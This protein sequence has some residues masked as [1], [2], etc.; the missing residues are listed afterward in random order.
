MALTKISTG[1]VK[2]DAA[3]QAKIADEAIDE[4]RLQVSNAG[5]N[6]QFLSKQSG[7]TGGLTWADVTIPD[8]DKCI[9]GNTSVEAVDTGSDGH[10]KITTEGT[11]RVR[12]TN[13]GKLGI[14]VTAPNSALHVHSP[15]VALG[16]NGNIMIKATT[17]GADVGGQITF[18]NDG[19]RR[20]AIAG[21]QEGSDALA[22]YLQFGTRGSS[23]D[24]SER[25]R[26]GSSGQLGVGGATYGTSGQVLTS[27]GAS[28]APSWADAGGGAWEVVSNHVLTGSTSDI[29][30]YGWSNTYAQY[31]VVFSGCYN[32]DQNLMRIRFYL[33]STSGNNGTLSTSSTYKRTGYKFTFGSTSSPGIDAGESSYFYPQVASMGTESNDGEL[34]FPMKTS[35]HSAGHKC[36][37]HWLGHQDYWGNV[38]CE[39]DANPTHFLTG[40]HIYFTEDTSTTA[41]APTSGRVTLLRMKTS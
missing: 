5:T 36:Y 20:A 32:A 1:G 24:V 19:A 38:T 9:E 21:N 29:Q 28:A 11:E 33:D 22:G 30:L 8:A 3:S 25:F 26:V 41:K 23:G 6:G 27:G 2:D 18:G 39:L 13:D 17:S 10:V 31:K 14:G 34:M 7:N 12:V 15:D 4:A 16:S 35:N 37:G 40:I